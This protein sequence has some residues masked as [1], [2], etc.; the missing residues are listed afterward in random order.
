MSTVSTPLPTERDQ[1]EASKPLRRPAWWHGALAV[2]TLELLVVSIFTYP[3]L[4]LLQLG[5]ISV[6]AHINFAVRFTETGVVYPGHFLYHGSVVLVHALL[7]ISWFQAHLGVIVGAQGVLAFLLWLL[8][9]RALGPVASDR[10]PWL[11]LLGALGLMVASAI[12]VLTWR[13]GNHYLGYLAPNAYLSQTYVVLQPFALLA[14]LAAVRTVGPARQHVGLGPWPTLGALAVLA[15]LAK[16]S[17]TIC[18][19]PASFLMLLWRDRLAGVRRM[20]TLFMALAVPVLAV[21]AWQ[22]SSTYLAV[23]NLDL[24]R[25]SGIR[26]APFMVMGEHSVRSIP[27]STQL[28]LLPKLLLAIAFPLTVAGVYWKEAVADLRLRL[29]W[30]QFAFGAFFAYFVAEFPRSSAGNFIWSGDITLF[31]LFVISLVF[32]AERGTNNSMSR[33]GLP[34]DRRI[35]LSLLV[36]LLHVGCG[37]IMVIF[38]TTTLPW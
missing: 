1:G 32:I 11:P 2:V 6:S 37:I 20:A 26:F 5:N 10:S 3:Q 7:P 23:Q 12:S 30:L 22:Y 4:R 31:I 25:D 14:F 28:W 27:G 38:P 17:Y 13:Y 18:I 24:A 8:L 29:A 33:L 15:T 9:R 21:L 34:Q 36:F 16:P 19:L 35:R